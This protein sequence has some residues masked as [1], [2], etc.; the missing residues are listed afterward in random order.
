[1]SFLIENKIKTLRYLLVW[2]LYVFFHAFSLCWL[3]DVPCWMLWVDAMV[4]AA[5]FAAFGIL[6]WNVLLYGNYDKIPILQKV[7][8]YSALAL[9]VVGLWICFGYGFNYLCLGKEAV[10]FFLP[11]LPLYAFLGLLLFLINILYFQNK[12]SEIKQFESKLDEVDSVSIE[13]T[14][15]NLLAVEPEILERIAVK[16]GH[17][18][19]VI[20]V[21]DIIYLQADGD[22]VTIHTS[23]GKYL[24]EQT[25]KYFQENLPQ[26]QFVRVHRSY[27]VNIESISRIEQYEKQNQLLTLKN[28]DKIKASI[29]GYKLLKSRLGL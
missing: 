8:N 1:M 19:H 22:Y 4:H 11:V 25:M 28:G 27:V 10:K 9:I 6:L 21:P 26:S 13:D 17:K 16:L 7:M 5:L 15:E 24:K 12:I 29:A 20:L 23:N 14:Q 18:I 3:L 2:A